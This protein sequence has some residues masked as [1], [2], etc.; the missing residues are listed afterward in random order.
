MNSVDR[1]VS[2][3]RRCQFYTP[4]G[5]RGGQC[6]L[7]NVSVQGS[8]SAC[9]LSAAPFAP[10]W[11]TDWRELEELIALKTPIELLEAELNSTALVELPLS[12][13]VYESQAVCESQ[14]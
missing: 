6:Q 13:A 10:T 9:T 5:R 11:T 3:C 8:W 7:L 1:P 4:E 2:A 14:V 12:Q